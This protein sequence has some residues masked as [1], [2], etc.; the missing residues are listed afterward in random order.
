MDHWNSARVLACAEFYARSAAGS[1]LQA[2][3]HG[4]CSMKS[5]EPITIQALNA[6]ALSARLKFPTNDVLLA[7]LMEEVGELANAL[8]EL[9]YATLHNAAGNEDRRDHVQKEAIQV[10]ATALRILEEGCS[11]FPQYC[12]APLPVTV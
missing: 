12:P 11:E 5:F 8:L 1:K 9:R 10:A 6:E 4:V 3:F 2:E 7:A